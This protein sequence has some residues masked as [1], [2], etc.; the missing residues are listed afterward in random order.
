[1]SMFSDKKPNLKLSQT[2]ITYNRKDIILSQ[3]QNSPIVN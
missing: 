2:P 3:A 1:M